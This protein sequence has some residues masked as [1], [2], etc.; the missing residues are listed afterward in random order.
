MQQL[1]KDVIVDET[2]KIG[3]NKLLFHIRIFE[4]QKNINYKL[5]EEKVVEVSFGGG[6]IINALEKYF[7]VLFIFEPKRK[8]PSKNS[9]R[10]YFVCK[11]K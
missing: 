5:F 8:S 2:S 3:K 1:G 11:L 9:E 4:N 6:K 10:L 7:K